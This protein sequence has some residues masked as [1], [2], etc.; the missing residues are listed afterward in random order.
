MQL[1]KPSWI[2]V[3]IA[4]AFWGFSAREAPAQPNLRILNFSLTAAQGGLPIPGTS[5]NLVVAPFK[6]SR[7]TS[8]TLLSYFATAFHTNWPAG[9]QLAVGG[10]LSQ[11]LVVDKTGTNPV[12][13]LSAGINVGD[14]NVA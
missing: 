7:I 3:A 5:S 10:G 9:A 6:T 8:K 14:T 13:N 11:V 12:C 1:K 2:A 4:V